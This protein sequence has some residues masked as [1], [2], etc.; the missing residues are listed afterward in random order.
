MA[1]F[2]P[3]PRVSSIIDNW[4]PY[5]ID[6]VKAVMDGTWEST[7]TW[8]GISTGMVG[9]GEISSAVPADVKAEAL[10][11]KDAIAAGE[12]HP[13]TGPINKQDG[14]PWLAEGETASDGDLLGMNFYI[15]GLTGD[16]PN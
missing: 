8:D 13:F 3:V 14:T 1:E 9:I 11:L 5:Y 16:V 10:A 12:Y 15:E 2:G 7:D 4:A 6:R